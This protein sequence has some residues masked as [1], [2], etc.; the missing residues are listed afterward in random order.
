MNIAFVFPG[1]GSQY[2]DMGKD[3]YENYPEAKRIYELAEQIL[4]IDIKSICFN[5]EINEYTQLAIFITEMAILEVIKSKGIKAEYTSG[6]SL[7]EYSAITY[8]NIISLENTIPLIQKRGEYMTKLIEPCK[9]KMIAVLGLEDSRVKE[10]CESIEGFIEPVNYNCPG[11]V[12]ISGEYEIVENS[13]ENFKTVGAK[14]IPLNVKSAFHTIKLNKAK[15]KLYNYLENIEINKPNCKIIKN[16]DGTEYTD[17]D[18]IK[19]ILANHIV[20]PVYFGKCIE[21]MIKNGVNTFIEIGPG[22]TL[23]GFIKKTNKDV[24]VINI[25]KIEDL[26][27]LEEFL[28]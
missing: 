27:K 19:E 6:L 28:C 22:K 23:S 12:V 25:E 9:Y 8:G 4:G 15:E 13:I 24:K 10:I 18:N 21:N 20:Q 2:K 5:A 17:K 14:V 7:G 3:F 1:Q 26:E 16:M 11:Q